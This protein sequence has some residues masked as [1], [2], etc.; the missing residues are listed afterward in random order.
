MTHTKSHGSSA[1][2]V[3][4]IALGSL[5][6]MLLAPKSGSEVR[7]SLKH[8]LAN[9]K[10]KIRSKADDAEENFDDALDE[11]KQTGREVRDKVHEEANRRDNE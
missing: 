2:F 10:D 4:G 7:K 6:A 8:G 3:A 5:V 11:A 1:A 9:V